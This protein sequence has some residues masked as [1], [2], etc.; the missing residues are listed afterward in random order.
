MGHEVVPSQTS[1]APMV[2]A[3]P[4]NPTYP[5]RN[6]TTEG[7]KWMGLLAEWDTKIEAFLKT[8]PAG[9]ELGELGEKGRVLAQM[10]GSRDQIRDAAKRL[11]REVTHMYHEDLERLEHAV[12]ALNRLSE[13]FKAL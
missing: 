1:A 4:R 7:P 5:R 10:I 3:I 11:P 6:H 8:V 9:K 13:K 2:A 12:A